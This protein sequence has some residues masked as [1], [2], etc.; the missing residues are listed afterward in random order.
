MSDML[1]WAVDYIRMGWSVIPINPEGNPKGK[2][3]LVSWMQFQG[4]AAT[5][6]EAAEW[7]SRW[8]DAN[9]GIVTGSV[10]N[11][12]VLDLDGKG[13]LKLLREHLGGDI[14]V[15]ASTKTG[16]GFHLY[17]GYSDSDIASRARIL[18]GDSCAMDVRGEG[19]YVVAPPS[20]HESGLVYTW[21]KGYEHISSL[22]LA[23]QHTLLN[24]PSDT[25]SVERDEATDHWYDTVAEGVES[26]S[27]NDTA[28]RVAGYWLR[29]SGGDAKVCYRAL[30]L[31]N[32]QNKPPLSDSELVTIVK[33]VAK[34]HAAREAAEVARSSASRFIVCAS[35]LA[36]E[37]AESEVRSGVHVQTPGINDVDGLVAGDQIVVA[38]RPG[39]GKSTFGTQLTADA[40]V[41]GKVPTLVVTT[42]MSRS[43]RSSWMIGHLAKENPR[44]LRPVPTR[45]LGEIRRSPLHIC[46][47]GTVHVNQIREMAEGIPG[48]GL[49]IVDHIGRIKTDKRERRDLEVE[50]VA[51]AFKSLAKDLRCTV[52]SLVQLSRDID[53]ES[54]PRRPRLS[55]LR[56]SGGIEQEA[57]SV[58]FIWPHR[59]IIPGRRFRNYTLVIGKF[60]HGGL[61]DVK[62]TFDTEHREFGPHQPEPEV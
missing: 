24:G 13:A 3:P 48:I 54:K 36:D 44:T 18:T 28:T 22:P 7:W 38:A 12:V 37:L 60:R 51:K 57:D 20:V 8:P 10:S 9:I 35:D 16:K 30:R 41:V 27:R 21:Y 43:E 5:E 46:D 61:Q 59:G 15:T 53:K 32:L 1:E 62:V 29:M 52:V 49:V 47:V 56:E 45:H 19:G 50:D 34:R 40:C 58:I 2:K 25:L 26:G 55:D 42:E 39:V 11:L 33:S 4:V 14:P 23:L 31:W 6:E 17:Y